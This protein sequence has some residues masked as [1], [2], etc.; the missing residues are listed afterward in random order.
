MGLGPFQTWVTGSNAASHKMLEV[1]AISRVF[2]SGKCVRV[3]SFPSKN[4]LQE[5]ALIGYPC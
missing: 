4:C 5:L 2:G 1:I 3:L